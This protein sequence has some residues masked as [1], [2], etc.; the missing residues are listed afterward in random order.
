LPPHLCSSLFPYTTLFRSLLP[1]L[2]R[3]L[4][5]AVDAEELHARGAW[6]ASRSASGRGWFGAPG[7]ANGMRARSGTSNAAA[8]RAPAFPEKR[9]E[10]HTSE[11]Q[12][13]G[14]LVCR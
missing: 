12:S 1:L 11:L 8:N 3:H 2:E 6:T 4:R 5:V 10:E 13:R 9:S 7:G 14:H